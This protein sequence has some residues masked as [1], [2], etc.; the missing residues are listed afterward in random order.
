MLFSRLLAAAP[1]RWLTGFVG[2]VL[3][4]GVVATSGADR[5]KDRPNPRE[6]RGLT[7]ATIPVQHFMDRNRAIMFIT[8]AGE[9]G[10]L[11]SSVAG[12]GFW[13]TT[14]NQYVFSSG[15]NMGALIP[16]TTPGGKDTVVAIGGPFS[17]LARGS[18]VFP[19]L[20]V[21]W[22]STDPSDAANFPAVCTV[23]D[24]R[25]AKFPA[26]EPFRGQPF[27]GFAD[28]TV[29]IAANDITGST[30]SACGGRR[31]GME[32]ANTYFVFSVPSV[33]DFFFAILRVF[34]RTEFI[35]AS[36][37][38]AQPPGPYDLEDTIIAFAED[39][40]VGDAT[41]DQVAFFPDIQTMAFWDVDFHED[42][43]DQTP[44][45]QGIT[46]LDF[47]TDPG[48]GEPLQLASFTVFTNGVPRP[49]PRSRQEWYQG[50]AGDPTFV[51]RE[52]SPRDVR[53]MVSSNKFLLPAG[54]FVELYVA[55][56]YA[57]VSGA[58]PA[59]LFAEDFQRPG[60]NTSP[61]FTEFRNV[62]RTSTAVFRAGFVVPTAPAKPG[63]TLIP[64]D[65]QITIVWD[66]VS[67]TGINPFA[68]VARNPFQA[69]SPATGELVAPGTI[70]FVPGRGFITA[71]EAGVVGAPVTNAAFNP[72][73]V[74]RD[75]QGFRVYRSRTGS[76]EDAELIFQVDL[77]DLI[78]ENALGFCVAAVSVFDAEGNFIRAVCTETIFASDDLRA[79]IGTN[80]GL[81]FSVVDRGGGFPDPG[82]GPGLI[83]GIPVFYS[84]TAFGV[85]CGLL[86][87][88]AAVVVP[89]IFGRPDPDA[90]ATITP[91][92]A[93]LSLES[94]LLP[95]K[96]ATPRSESSA[97]ETANV[98]F[99]PLKAD[100]TECNPDEPAYTVDATTGHYTD[101]IDCS[102]AIDARLFANRPLNIPSGEFILVIDRLEAPCDPGPPPAC[103][104]LATGGNTAFFHWEKADGSPATEVVASS[105]SFE[106]HF[107]LAHGE[108]TFL[109]FGIDAVA[110]DI[111]NDFDLSLVVNTDYAALQDLEVNGQ[112]VHLHE[113][114][115]THVGET[116]PHRVT[117]S[118]LADLVNLGMYRGG[119]NAR[120]YAHPGQFA[121]AAASFEL[122]WEVEGGN[123][124]GTVRRLPGGEIIPEGGQPKNA[125]NPHTA[126]D[127]TA[128][129]NWG[130]IAPGTLATVAAAMN[131][132]TAGP[133][134][135][136]IQL[137][138]GATFAVVVPGNSVLIS[139][140]KQVPANGDTW[141]IRIEGCCSPDPNGPSSG[142]RE[143]DAPTGPFRFANASTSSRGDQVVNVYP[144]ARWKLVL[145]GGSNELAA[146]DLSTIRVVPNPFIA[147][148]EITRGRGLQRILFTN[149][150]PTATIRI[151]TIS[152]NLVRV[153][154]HN[155]GGICIEICSGTAEWDVRS[156][157]DLLVASGNYYAHVTTA[158]GR[159][160]LTRFAVIN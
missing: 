74:I 133:L 31:L 100:G 14:A 65:R 70:V 124:S 129:Y 2:V 149:L 69:G 140:L 25:I 96:S 24:F 23:D 86:A 110:T 153:L 148:N 135:N 150:P 88:G 144:G 59:Q 29:C 47:G 102:N 108:A 8:D 126:G 45:F 17:E 151:Y 122:T 89:T 119:T 154:E 66:A 134:T 58:P 36:N 97:F 91:P 50:M 16:S 138:P 112:S 34:N 55:Y 146:A 30:C 67:V 3:L 80:T 105:G 109:A 78:T 143:P 61:A 51:I 40:D 54:E 41:D 93:C 123:F 92:A 13:I 82:I 10:A 11:A 28:Q 48:T 90:L 73:F 42:Q 137:A 6:G 46:A 121:T 52:V 21:F 99:F 141:V 139:G 4:L 106:Q 33:Q 156:R 104:N 128:G 145:S 159:T 116:R 32:T 98:R 37:S 76:P 49:D 19:G 130:F 63:F 94:G 114:G 1:R 158:D 75:F 83:N 95:F 56:F 38:P 117:G 5:P 85:N 111:G 101:I 81:A 142:G 72:D 20:D 118:S 7:P 71:E 115:G 131:P 18:L 125:E 152:G 64:G 84:V 68:Q 62:Q 136:T 22:D 147:V 57:N 160:H 77:P 120:E 87:G 43:F 27:P 79:A 132:P 155:E 103:Y 26:L 107:E 53:G 113:L 127:F 39:G 12:G 15:V 35:D 44:G 157:F 9:I 60:A